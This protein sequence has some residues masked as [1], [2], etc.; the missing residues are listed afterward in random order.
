[1]FN[2]NFLN[3][4]G[5]WQ[6]GWKED[7]SVRLQ[8]AKQLKGVVAALPDRFKQVSQ[9]CYRKRFL[10]NGE[11]FEIIMVDEKDEGLTSWTISQKYAENFKGLQEPAAVSAEIFE[12]TPIE[13]KEVK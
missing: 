8:L 7:Q 6:K 3:I 4:L 2:D 10:L 5:A 11:L 13:N 12:H 1:M 9:N